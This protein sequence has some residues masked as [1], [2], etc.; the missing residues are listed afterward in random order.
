MGRNRTWWNGVIRS[1]GF[2]PWRPE[3]NTGLTVSVAVEVV[4]GA[5]SPE[6]QLGRLVQVELT[7]ERA[8][9]VA[10]NLYE[11]AEKTDAAIEEAITALRA[12][13]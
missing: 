4:P 6:H 9:Q 11:Y 7:P 1:V 2:S 13:R 5:G 12:R 10:D 8:R 3:P